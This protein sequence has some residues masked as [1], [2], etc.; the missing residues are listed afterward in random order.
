MAELSNIRV[1]VAD[2][3]ETDIDILVDTLGD[4]LAKGHNLEKLRA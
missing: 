1:L 2:D 4:G 3:T